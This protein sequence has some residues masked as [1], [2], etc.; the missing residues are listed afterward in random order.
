MKPSV[1]K[2][3]FVFAETLRL[4]DQAALSS[5]PL[6]LNLISPCPLHL[7]PQ[8]LRK[9]VTNHQLGNRVA[10]AILHPQLQLTL[11]NDLIIIYETA[12]FILP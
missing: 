2:A 10:F 12:K 5:T 6:P 7:V 11:I 9:K 3:H 8:L 4:V 1:I